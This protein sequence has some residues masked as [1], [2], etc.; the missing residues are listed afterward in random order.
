MKI[1]VQPSKTANAL[2]QMMSARERA[3]F[4]ELCETVP[5]EVGAKLVLP[6]NALKHV[7]FP[8]SGYISLLTADKVAATLEV[9]IVGN[10]G[11]F[12]AT[13]LLGVNASLVTALV[14]GSGTALRI[15]AARFRQFVA[16]HENAGT[17]FN[18]YLYYSIAQ[19]SQSAACN[20]SHRV[21][22]RLAR[23]LLTTQDCAHS[24]LFT[25]THQFLAYMLGV[26]RAGVTEAAQLLQS[27]GLISYCRGQVSVL[28]RP[29]LEAK[30][31]G[32]YEALRHTYQ[33]TM[34]VGRPRMRAA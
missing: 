27:A 28:D 25:M 3:E 7:Y 34:R 1:V 22:V 4:A 15:T 23:W 5:L 13:L 14:Q 9:G 18:R 12:G 21:D 20:R 16:H 30:A 26:R 32:C 11:M 10:E 8:V 24:N 33:S 31:C 29:A 2:L 6:G 19:L 17:I